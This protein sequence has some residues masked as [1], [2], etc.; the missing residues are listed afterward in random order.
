MRARVDP[1]KCRTVGECVKLCPEAFR[2]LEG[3]KKATV[4]LDPIPPRLE[5]RVCQAARSC[6]EGAISIEA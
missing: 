1:L 4:I 5:G 2:F 3:S 6:P